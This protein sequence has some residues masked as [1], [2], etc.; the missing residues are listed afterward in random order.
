VREEE[1]VIWN[2]GKWEKMKREFANLGRGEG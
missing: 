1:T 2:F